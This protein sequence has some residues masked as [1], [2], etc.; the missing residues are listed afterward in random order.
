LAP[1]ERAGPP[2]VAPASPAPPAQPT[3]VPLSLVVLISTVVAGAALAG[4][5]V[6]PSLL[7]P[8]TQVATEVPAAGLPVPSAAGPAPAGPVGRQPDVDSVSDE[9]QPGV[10]FDDIPGEAKKTRRP[11]VPKLGDLERGEVVLE[12]R[13]GANGG[14]GSRVSM[15]GTVSEYVQER[16]SR[17]PLDFDKPLGMRTK[18]TVF[19]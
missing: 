8:R 7:A 6:A 16:R 4:V 9:D 15:V 14:H 2:R 13:A 5:A 1:V 12:A 18:S 3:G 11:Q 19:V 17:T 10:E